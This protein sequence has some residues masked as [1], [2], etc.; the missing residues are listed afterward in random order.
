M[1]EVI[2][3]SMVN[4]MLSRKTHLRCPH[5][6]S[7]AFWFQPN[8]FEKSYLHS[9]MVRNHGRN[10]MTGLGCRLTTQKGYVKDHDVCRW[11]SD[12]T[13]HITSDMV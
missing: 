10:L 6:I 11:L 4:V 9:S 8:V 2:S 13:D 3:E 5:T 12:K 7:S 1:E